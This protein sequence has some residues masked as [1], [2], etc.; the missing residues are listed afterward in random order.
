M[1]MSRKALKLVQKTLPRLRL[2]KDM[3]VLPPTEHILRAYLF[4]RTPYKE[5]FYLWRVVLPLYRFNS[6]RILNY[7]YRI[8]K[9]AYVRLSKEAPEQTAVE[10]TRI[11][12][13]DLGKLE[14]I[15]GPLDFL[16]H[17]GWMI[18]NDAPAFMLDLAVTYF[19]VG[20]YH[21][22][23]ST[24]GEIP[25]Q[26]DKLIAWY[27]P[28]HR[29]SAY[30]AEIRRVAVRLAKDI[31]S[32]PAAAAHMISEWERVNIATLELADTIS[33][34]IETSASPALCR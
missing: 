9:G 5:T 6:H 8:P 33:E 4:E 19:L 18:G 31:R 14:M 17:V 11:I 27:G 30:F 12:A 22:A 23:M 24:L 32:D 3:L 29:G 21:E 7:S 16:D 28:G 25:Q 2:C 1:S 13:E 26:A 10:V 34:G 15:R 20:R